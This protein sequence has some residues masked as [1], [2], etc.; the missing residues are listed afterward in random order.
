MIA[1]A[2]AA[3][4]DERTPEGRLLF[5]RT[6]FVLRATIAGVSPPERFDAIASPPVLRYPAGRAAIV[7]LAHP[8]QEGAP[9]GDEPVAWRALQGPGAAL[10]LTDPLDPA[11]RRDLALLW[12]AA[13]R[14]AAPRK[15]LAEPLARLLTREPRRLALLAAVDLAELAHTGELPAGVRRVLLERLRDPALWPEIRPLLEHALAPRGH[16]QPAP[17]PPSP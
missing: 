15:R 7:A 4:H 13:K 14:P 5:A 12:N 17:P 10:V 2:T 11:V 1:E 8:V 16:R 9:S 6:P 3:T